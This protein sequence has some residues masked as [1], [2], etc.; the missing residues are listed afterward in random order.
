[1]GFSMGSMFCYVTGAPKVLTGHYG[2]SPQQFGGL[3]GLNGLAFMTAS[4]LN[5]VALRTQQPSEILARF[6]WVPALLGI[7][8]LTMSAAFDPRLWMVAALQLSL[9]VAVGRVNPNVSAIALAPHARDAGAA[10]AFLGA[11]QS[12]ITTLAGLAVAIFND[13]TV[14]TLAAIMCSAAVLAF[15]SYRWAKPA[16]IRSLDEESL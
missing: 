16:P 12:A 13:G 1:M 9:F 2:L 4:R 7:A 5:M 8:L 14:R 10:S 15:L 3:I 11:V 6:I